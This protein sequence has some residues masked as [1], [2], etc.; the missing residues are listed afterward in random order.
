MMGFNLPGRKVVSCDGKN[1]LYLSPSPLVLLEQVALL[2]RY[3]QFL[4]FI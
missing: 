3:M 4:Y 1:F 2:L